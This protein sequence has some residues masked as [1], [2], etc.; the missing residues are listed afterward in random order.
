MLS[1]AVVHQKGGTGKTTVAINLAACAHLQGLRTIIIDMDIQASALDW[2]AKRP[3]GSRLDGLSV[4]APPLKDQ[5]NALT[6][7]RYAEVTR[8]YDV[9]LLDGP[10]RLELITERAAA[11]ADL[12]L[13][14]VGPGAFDHWALEP[15]RASIDRADVLR[16]GLGR[17]PV[18]RA[19]VMNHAEAGTVC[20]AQA[21]AELSATGELLGTVRHLAAFNRAAREGQSVFTIGRAQ[22]AAAD[23]ERLWRAVSGTKKRRRA[24]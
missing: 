23:I 9:V 11:V 19:Y 18:R 6:P 14:P 20:S 17:P 2:S 22:A 15:T 24:A 1:I 13:M 21:L 8:G 3:E 16:E 7:A 10:A 4:I 12:V 5:R